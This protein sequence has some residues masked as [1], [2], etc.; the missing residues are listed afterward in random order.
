MYLH[1]TFNSLPL[2]L[3]EACTPGHTCASVW[4]QAMGACAHTLSS[5]ALPLMPGVPLPLTPSPPY[6]CCTRSYEMST[7]C[8]HFMAPRARSSS[9]H[10]L[11][12]PSTETGVQDAC[13]CTGGHWPP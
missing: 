13:L 12:T 1:C 4:A 11:M 7:L 9:H 2:P 10:D 3:C 8:A 6:A 5:H